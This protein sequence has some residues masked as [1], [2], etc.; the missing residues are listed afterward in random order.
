LAYFKAA[1]VAAVHPDKIVLAA[2]TI[3]A[4]ESQII[5][6]PADR[7][8]ARRILRRLSG[9][10]HSVITGVVLL[11][12]AS[13]RRRLQHCISTVRLC[14]LDDRAIA[15]YLDTGAWEGKAGA[16]GIQD[17]DDPFVEKISGSFTNVVGLPMELVTGMFEQW[18]LEYGTGAE[19]SVAP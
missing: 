14:T 5:G 11:Q 7:E 12:R 1:G 4:L 16:Y 6:K 19:S 8:D 17:Q 9:T 15:T 10:T 2:D 3:A 18:V 13:G